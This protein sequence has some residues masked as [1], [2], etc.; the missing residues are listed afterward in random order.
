MDVGAFGRR[1]SESA[2]RHDGDALAALFGVPSSALRRTAAGLG[3]ASVARI[4]AQLRLEAPWSEIAAHYVRAAA[5]LFHPSAASK[6]PA[7]VWHSA[8]EALQSALSHFLRA[9][10]QWA[11]GRWALP[12]LFALLRALRWA[13]QGADDAAN[14]Q[15]ARTT[16]AASVPP[17]QTH[18]EECA[19]LLNKAFSACIADRQPALSQSKKWGTYTIVGMLFRMYFTLKSTALCKNILRAL[20]AADLPP[21]EAYPRAD[22][23]TFAYY[24]GR[25][26]FLD[27]EYTKAELE[28][29]YALAELPHHA[30]SQGERIL[31]YLVAVRMLRGVRP[32][33]Q[34]LHRY[35]RVDAL[36]APLL[37]A[38]WTGDLRTY[39][40]ALADPAMERALV[41]LGL[42]LALE[43]ARDICL[44][45]LV[46]L[47][48]VHSQRATRL[49][50][51]LFT[52]ALHWLQV[53]VDPEETEWMLATLIAKG[54][55]KGYLA[56]E[57]Q[58]LVLS[59]HQPF[60]PATLAMLT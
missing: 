8:C 12:V 43:R 24:V 30:T 41:R 3:D 40:A 49:R 21:I 17:I 2:A 19:R 29:G 35:P 53:P 44:A 9:F 59:A 27:E 47:V 25:L 6:E 34:L 50:F 28:L 55:M 23:V 51:A 7:E 46:R 32:T 18:R 52:D 15:R 39:D 1:V 56:H 26:A 57:R 38:Y 31:L 4:A 13:A 33:R 37:A 60:P 36:Y 5:L 16:P 58:T 54:R 42:Y 22:R 20:A 48:W 11:A 45:R 14:A 10:G